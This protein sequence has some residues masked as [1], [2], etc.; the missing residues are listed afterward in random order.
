MPEIGG[1]DEYKKKNNINGDMRRYY[2]N[3]ING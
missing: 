3:R 2:I 1:S